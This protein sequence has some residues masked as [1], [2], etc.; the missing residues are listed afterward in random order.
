MLETIDRKGQFI[1]R[2]EVV[3]LPIPIPPSIHGWM[4]N[5]EL[6]YLYSL[7]SR[8]RDDGTVGDLLEVGSYRGLSASALG[9]AGNLTCVDTFRGGEDLPNSDS[10]VDFN[11][12]M[13]TMGL[14][15]RVFEGRSQDVLEN[16]VKWGELYRLVFIDGSHEYLNVKRDL[17][18]GWELLSPGG[19]L[20]A[21]DYIGFPGVTLA[22]DESG[23]G[24]VPCEPRRSKMA[25]AFKSQL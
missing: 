25:V 23:H 5:W 7:A 20:V 17:E 12:A 14:T 4:W 10:R 8:L 24:F 18:L 22:C 16:L 3:P 6:L 11:V 19:A 2:S 1:R 21:D 13:R 9:Q 15:P